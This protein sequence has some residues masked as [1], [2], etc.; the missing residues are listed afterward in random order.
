MRS[1]NFS[2][3]KYVT[4]TWEPSPW[5]T[6]VCF[7]QPFLLGFPTMHILCAPETRYFFFIFIF[8]KTRCGFTP[9][10]PWKH[11]FANL[12]PKQWLCYQFC[13]QVKGVWWQKE[14]MCQESMTLNTQLQDASRWRIKERSLKEHPEWLPRLCGRERSIFLKEEGERTSL[15][16]RWGWLWGAV[17]DKACKARLGKTVGGH[18]GQ[19]PKSPFWGIQVPGLSVSLSIDPFLHLPTH[20]N[21]WTA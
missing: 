15:I 21:N 16:E 12:D 13:V 2:K 6:S 19:I 7:G 9:H 17:K 1:A 3:G 14:E 8:C 4:C 18:Q 11:K 20:S 10:T 5:P